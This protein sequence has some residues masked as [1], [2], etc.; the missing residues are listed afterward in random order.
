[1]VARTTSRTRTSRN[2]RLRAAGGARNKD[3]GEKTASAAER[4]RTRRASSKPAAS[5]AAQESPE[6]A[7]ADAKPA[8]AKESPEPTTAGDKPPK[9]TRRATGGRGTAAAQEELHEASS[10]ETVSE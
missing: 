3:A 5:E 2:G 8:A 1:M 10:A 6:A 4:L 9:Q 7:I